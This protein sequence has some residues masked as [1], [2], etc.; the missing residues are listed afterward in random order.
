MGGIQLEGLIEYLQNIFPIYPNK[1][2][3]DAR[4]AV[5]QFGVQNNRIQ[6]LTNPVTEW[7][8]G[9]ILSTIPFLKFT[10]DGQISNFKAP[11]M[12]I[13]SSCDLDR[14]ET[15]VL[16]PC[17]PLKNFEKF[18]CYAEIPKNRVF[19]FFYIGYGLTGDEWVVDLSRPMTL[20]R[21]RVLKRIEEGDIVRLHSLTQIGW[22]LFITKFSM[23]YFRPDDPSTMLERKD[24]QE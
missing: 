15:I 21:N 20:L 16:C 6:V 5:E 10:E 3:G 22:Y 7:S 12:I 17:F 13:T 2:T 14:K 11:G 9:D 18:G 19:E 8:Q 4:L 23:N 24:I 1:T